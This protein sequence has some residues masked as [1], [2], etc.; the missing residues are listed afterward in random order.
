MPIN[1]G[2]SSLLVRAV[3]NHPHMV[4]DVCSCFLIVIRVNAEAFVLNGLSANELNSVLIWP[5]DLENMVSNADV[6][7]SQTHAYRS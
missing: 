7:S 6:L 3:S 1:I 4:M 2:V 5:C